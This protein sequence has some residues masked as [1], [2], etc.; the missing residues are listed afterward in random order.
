MKC[1]L[2]S[3]SVTRKDRIEGYQEL[4]CLKKEC[5]WWDSAMEI[6]GI[7]ALVCILGVLSR[8]VD[9]MERKMPHELQF[10]K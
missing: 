9:N 10:R 5:A 3:I 8:S 7:H 1:P 6:C 4:D 2:L